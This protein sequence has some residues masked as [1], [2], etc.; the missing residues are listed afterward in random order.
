MSKHEGEIFLFQR[1]YVLDWLQ[2][3]FLKPNIESHMLLGEKL[4][5]QEGQVLINS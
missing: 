3:R 5:L 1:K 4:M 2:D